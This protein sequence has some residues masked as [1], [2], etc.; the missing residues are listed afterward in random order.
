MSTP[1]V[2]VDH[3]RQLEALASVLSQRGFA[4]T[5]VRGTRHTGIAVTSRR[6]ARMSEDIYAAQVSDGS[7]WF[8]WSCAER[9]APIGE[10]TRA[11]DAITY[12]LTP[13]GSGM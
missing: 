13:D 6:T 10:I 2:T 12:V 9:I 7:W 3:I 8:F 1:H 5:M 4:T 11:A